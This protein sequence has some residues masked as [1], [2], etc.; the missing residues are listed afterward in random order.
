MTDALDELRQLGEELRQ[1]FS[2]ERSAIGRLDHQALTELAE[3]KRA[4][5]ERLGAIRDGALATGSPAV[6]ALFAAIRVE[7]QATAML[8][9]TATAAVRARLGY[10]Q[11]AGYDRRA[12]TITHAPN[13]VLVAY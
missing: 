10:D 1:V 2:D 4:L 8:A 13:R 12:R 3:R 6:R 7:A 5:A 9:A 11:G